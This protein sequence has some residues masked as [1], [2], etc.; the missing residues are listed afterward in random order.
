MSTWRLNL[1]KSSGAFGTWLSLELLDFAFTDFAGVQRVQ[2]AAL[3]PGFAWGQ[4]VGTAALWG[5]HH[6]PYLSPVLQ[7]GRGGDFAAGAGPGP[8]AAGPV[9][10]H[11]AACFA[12]AAFS[13]AGVG[14]AAAGCRPGADRCARFRRAAPTR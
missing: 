8:V 10:L 2:R 3:H 12:A 7:C 11:D 13:G 14:P 1:L 6:F 9:L 4:R 5:R